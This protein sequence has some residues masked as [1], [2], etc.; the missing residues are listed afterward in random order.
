MLVLDDMVPNVKIYN[1]LTIAVVDLYD[2]VVLDSEGFSLELDTTGTSMTAPSK[3]INK[4][5]LFNFEDTIWK[6][7]RDNE[8]TI[9]LVTNALKKYVNVDI[10]GNTNP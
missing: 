9:K 10:L 8:V 3:Y 1:D 6:Y 5:G 2:Q 4:R 7:P